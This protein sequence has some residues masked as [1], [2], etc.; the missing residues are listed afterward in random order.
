ME[1]RRLDAPLAA[2]DH[3]AAVVTSFESVVLSCPD[4]SAVLLVASLRDELSGPLGVWVDATDAYPAALVARDVA[5][6]AWLVDL[7]H[8]VVDGV[9]PHDA[10]AVVRHLLTNDEVNF[11]NSVSTLRGAYNRPAPPRPVT[12]WAHDAGG[13]ESPGARLSVVGRD[14]S[15]AGTVTRFA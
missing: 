1:L 3:I 9:H 5:T 8:V 7:E 15:A 11:A 2:R 4:G 6:L 14:D 10:A 13:L 12:V